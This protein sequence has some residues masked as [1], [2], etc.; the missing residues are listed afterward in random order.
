MVNLLSSGTPHIHILPQFCNNCACRLEWQWYSALTS[1]ASS[2]VH[3][4]SDDTY[5]W[6]WATVIVSSFGQ[7]E[8]DA[9]YIRQSLILLIPQKITEASKKT[10]RWWIWR[11][12]NGVYSP[13]LFV[14][15]SFHITAR[16]FQT[17]VKIL[18]KLLKNGGTIP[19][20]FCINIL[21]VPVNPT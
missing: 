6:N 7:I 13:Y 16:P 10:K 1:K 5:R 14:H 21:N 15:R 17:Q 12:Y 9:H 4:V 2:K 8:Q 18:K 20:D 3:L 19:I 11:S